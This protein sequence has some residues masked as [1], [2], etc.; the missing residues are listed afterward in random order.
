MR[1]AS[2]TMAKLA[3]VLLILVFGYATGAKAE[4]PPL[5]LNHAWS[6]EANQVSASFG[7]AVATAGDVNGD[8][9][10]DLVVGA[11][12]F[13]NGQTNEGRAFVYLSSA[14]GL[15]V[16]PSWT[17]ESNQAGASFGQA[18]GT[19]G[20]VNGDGYDDLIV[21]APEYANEEPNEGQVS[22]YLG[23]ASGLATD[24]DWVFEMNEASS[25]LGWAVG[26]AGDVNRDG[27][28]DVIVSSPIL[29]SNFGIAM[30]FHG[31]P[32]G[33]PDSADWT[34]RGERTGDWFGTSSGTAGD[35]NGDGYADVI[36]GASSHDN[37][38]TDEGRA[39]VYFGSPSGLST[40]P[41]WTA[42]SNQMSAH[43][44]TSVATAGDTN[45]DGYTDVIVGSGQYSNG[46]SLEG[47]AFL[48][49]G[50][51]T[52]PLPNPTWSV[53][54][55]Q[56]GAHFG[57]NVATAGDVN[58]DGY[59]DVLVSATEFDNGELT[60]GRGFLYLGSPG[61]LLLSPSWTGEANQVEAWFGTSL[62]TAGDVNGDG[63]ADVVVGIP[64]FDNG[65]TNEGQ[66]RLYYGSATGTGSNARLRMSSLQANA[67]HGSSGAGCGDV[68]GDGFSDYIIGA[69]YHDNGQTDEGFAIVTVGDFDDSFTLIEVESN[70]DHAHLG[71]SVSGAGDVNGDGYSDVIIGAPDFDNGQSNEGRAYVHLG[72]PTGTLPMPAWIVEGNQAEVN[73]GWSVA[74]AG[75]VNGDGF[76]DVIVG[77]P[78]F[79]N[80][81]DS[82]GRAFVYHGSA[83]GLST[84]PA[85]RT[86]SNQ[87]VAAYGYSVASAG[88]VNRDG[89]SD[90]IVGATLFD[91]GQSNEGRAYV[92]LGSATGL[93]TTPSWTAESNQAGADFGVSVG[94]AGD[95]NG[96]GY[97]DVIIGADAY[98]NGQGDEG[99]AY[100]Y[101]GSASGIVSSPLW[102]GELDQSAAQF[103]FSV[104]TA[105]DVNNDGFSD[106]VIGA[107]FYDA[108]FVDEGGAFVYHG[109][110]AGPLAAPTTTI[111]KGEFGAMV[112]HSV[113]LIGDVNGDGFSDVLI[114][115]PNYD[116]GGPLTDGGW[117]FAHLGNGQ[118]SRN[119]GPERLPRQARVNNSAPIAL[120][121]KSPQNAFFAKSFGR[122]A[123][124]RGDVRMEIEVKPLG[125]PFD[126]QDVVTSDLVDT[127]TPIVDRGSRVS[128]QEAILGLDSN[129]RYRWRMRFTSPSPF[130]PRTPWFSMAGNG[131]TETDF[132][133][134]GTVI[135][136]ENPAPSAAAPIFLAPISPNPFPASGEIV[137]S[138]AQA[139]P[140]RLVV[141]DVQGRARVMLKEG[142]AAPGRHAVAWD[143]RSSTGGRL[144][145]GV[146]FVRLTAGNRV[147]TR[148]LTIVR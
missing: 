29:D 34:V 66:A 53:E 89:F 107:I 88:D 91:N 25:Y 113:S 33:L 64:N 93:S 16:T 148:K 17:A 63:F 105:G 116:Q 117:A 48:Y 79:D 24:P 97:S 36:V 46:Q 129:A 137:Y 84:S 80:G 70:Q 14:S 130:F 74:S 126:G 61:S 87:S 81:Q 40:T 141:Y 123:A 62:G 82:E 26:T 120:L 21:G 72:S 55:N 146:Y 27:Y 2:S 4:L 128:I 20:D 67:F 85:W 125:A 114:G 18:V 136:V 118:D 133:T 77:A 54:S 124:G 44:A 65:Q 43:F 37:G 1:I 73:Y 3:V 140:V 134:G 135:G 69:P 39:Y 78:Q 15:A 86:E 68:N 57:D 127:G 8:G 83:T 51:A 99:R 106:L 31:S 56:T 103:G 101:K 108:Q 115:A 52:G 9:Y 19:A 10:S 142:M 122:I 28:A 49:R 7:T 143:G 104:S 132:R 138:V 30:V 22:V 75:D 12:D 13:D 112:G 96:D 145:A 111:V 76:G 58:G 23:S 102:I 47:K 109:S 100:V 32:A 38:Q 41:G 71:W 45:G 35:V 139:T 60:E 147:E 50:S 90:V 95:V 98:D 42:E 144:E 6:A 11:H 121:G 94:T 119:A 5:S 110:P 131:F 92:Y 59:A